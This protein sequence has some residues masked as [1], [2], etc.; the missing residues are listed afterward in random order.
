MQ[1][2]YPSP[3][4]FRINSARIKV[5]YIGC[6]L[7]N[8]CFTSCSVQTFV[9]E[10]CAIEV[11]IHKIYNKNISIKGLRYLILDDELSM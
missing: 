6:F 8:S 3:F 11:T 2:N 10:T 5:R 7:I 4:S 1:K 9:V